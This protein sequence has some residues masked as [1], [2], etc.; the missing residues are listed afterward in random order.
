MALNSVTLAD[1][2]YSKFQTAF[3]E[4]PVI[5]EENV[6]KFSTAIAEAV[7]EHIKEHGDIVI[8]TAHAGVQRD[9]GTSVPTLAP[10]SDV[11]LSGAID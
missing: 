4:V 6:R 1:L 9:P 5:A 2:I 3:G 10:S 11:R 8:T 7:V